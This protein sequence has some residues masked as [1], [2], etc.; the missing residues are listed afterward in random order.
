[1]HLT[2][3]PAL[4]GTYPREMKDKGVCT[5]VYSDFIELLKTGVKEECLSMVNK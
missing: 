3:Y 1:M 4:L 2:T 5:N